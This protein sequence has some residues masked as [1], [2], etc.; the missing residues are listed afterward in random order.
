MCIRDRSGVVPGN[1]AGSDPGV[2]V[3]GAAG[4]GHFK[5]TQSHHTG[6]SGVEGVA[7]GFISSQAVA[8][9]GILH[10]SGVVQGGFH[11]GVILGV[12][13]VGVVGEGHEVHVLSLIHISTPSTAIS[14]AP[15]SP[16]SRRT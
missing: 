4:P 7:G 12:E 15:S 16:R 13:I 10:Q 8:G 11:V 5:A 9:V 6:I 14:W 2:D 1:H 3:A